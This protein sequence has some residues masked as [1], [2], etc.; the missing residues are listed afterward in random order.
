[1]EQPSDS[2]VPPGLSTSDG[3]FTLQPGIALS[4]QNCQ[5]TAATCTSLSAATPRTSRLLRHGSANLIDAAIAPTV[6]DINEPTYS[7]ANVDQ[8]PELTKP[9]IGSLAKQSSQLDLTLLSRLPRELRDQIWREAVVEDI[10]IPINVA[11]Y[12]TKD[13][14][15]RH[16]LQLEPALML[17]CKQTRHE[18]ADIYYLENT[19]SIA[20]DL[21]EERAIREL[22]RALRPWA[23]RMTKLEISHDFVREEGFTAEIE[24]SVSAPEGRILFEPMTF[25]TRVSFERERTACVIA[26]SRMCYCKAL[27][28]ALEHGSGNVLDWTQKYVSLILQS[29]RTCDDGLPW[30]W[31][32]AGVSVF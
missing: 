11:E 17:V 8:S 28:L 24:F 31:S 26:N 19:F 14:E 4:D 2:N 27:Q 9:I 18:A 23:D 30:C 16:R 12:N 10:E 7:T 20:D 3:V 21:F 22:N 5:L 29:Q 13:G 6:P 15:H 1:M 32:C 25:L